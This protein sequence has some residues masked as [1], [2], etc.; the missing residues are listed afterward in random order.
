[1]KPTDHETRQTIEAA[2]ALAGMTVASLTKLYQDDPEPGPLPCRIID[3][4]TGRTLHARRI[5]YPASK[6]GRVSVSPCWPQDAQRRTH[7]P[8]RDV[9]AAT[10]APDTPPD[11]MAKRLRAYLAETQDAHDEAARTAAAHDAHDNQTAA[12]VAALEAA[13]WKAHPS[14][15]CVVTAPT[16]PGN[17]Y[18]MHEEIHGETLSFQIRGITAAQAIAII[19]ALK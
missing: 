8:R 2:A 19:T 10:M 14:R 5:T 16:L 4:A 15:Q 3:P 17:A 13:G 11:R 12:T 7:P 6:A 18:I 9:A 1:M